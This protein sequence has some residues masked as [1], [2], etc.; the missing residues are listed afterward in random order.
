MGA[1]M[2]ATEYDPI[3]ELHRLR[4]ILVDDHDVPVEHDGILKGWRREKPLLTQLRKAAAPDMGATEGGGSAASTKV[5][6]NVGAVD[7]YDRIRYE[8]RE[9]HSEAVGKQVGSL[10]PDKHLSQWLLL[11]TGRWRQ[12]VASEGEARSAVRKVR[13]WITNINDLLDPPYRYPILRPCPT[14]GVSRHTQADGVLGYALNVTERPNPN[15]W[16]IHCVACGTEWAGENAARE[17]SL[18]IDLAEQATA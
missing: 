13:G 14:C 12:Q 4:T 6:L 3:A 10:L 16:F 2:T 18:A 15:D 17:L 11:F 5:P 9:M 1:P 8:A 7:L